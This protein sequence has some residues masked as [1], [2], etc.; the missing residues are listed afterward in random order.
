[1]KKDQ[2][3]RLTG[4]NESG[5]TLTSYLHNGNKKQNSFALQSTTK[6]CGMSV[7]VG[8]RSDELK[9]YLER[10]WLKSA[11]TINDPLVLAKDAS[12]E[13]INNYIQ[14][15]TSHCIVD[16]SNY[17]ASSDTAMVKVNDDLRHLDW[18]KAA[19]VL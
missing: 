6:P 2:Y 18:K 5:I 19:R 8:G 17:F 9:T 14:S 10:Y 1:M 3:V 15:P 4:V 16:F 7:L 11:N 12:Q 13:E